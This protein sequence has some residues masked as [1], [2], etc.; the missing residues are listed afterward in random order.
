[1]LEAIRICKNT[2]GDPVRIDS[3]IMEPTANNLALD[4]SKI[5]YMRN[6][7]TQLVVSYGSRVVTS[8]EIVTTADTVDGSGYSFVRWTPRNIYCDMS[9]LPGVGDTV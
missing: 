4:K 2:D 6:L 9:D 1:M 8:I 7:T 3:I 5:T